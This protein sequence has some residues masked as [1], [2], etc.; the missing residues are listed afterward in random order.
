MRPGLRALLNALEDC[1]IEEWLAAR[2]PGSSAWIDRY[3]DRLFPSRGAG[4]TR[5]PLFRQFCLGAIHE[6]WHGEL[7]PL[8]ERAIAALDTTRDARRAFIDAMP[9]TSVDADL[10]GAATYFAS[11]L[12]TRFRR[13]DSVFPP[14]SFERAVR[15]AAWQSWSIAWQHIRPE[16]ERLL[17][18]D[19]CCKG[20]EVASA[21]QQLLL[22]LRE[23]RWVG[24][25]RG[26]RRVV[27]VSW[28]AG[29]PF[30]GVLSSPARPMGLPELDPS[31]RSALQATVRAAP[32]NLWDEAFRVVAPLAD[33][34]VDE[35][36][37]RLLPDAFPRW[38]PGYATGSRLDLRAATQLEADPRALYRLWQRKT[39]PK[40]VDPAFF[41]L[42]DLSGSMSGDRIE[43]GFRG[44]V[45]LAS[46]LER[47][48]VPFAVEG[49]QDVPIPFK[50]LG[51]PLDAAA[52]RLLGEMPHECEARRRNGHNE[53]GHNHD[54]PV[55]V[56]VAARF[57]RVTATRRLLVVVSDGL[58]SG[59]SSGDPELLL[60]GAIRSIEAAGD[61]ELIGV[62]I[63]PGTDHVA[64]LY[65]RSLANVPLAEFPMALGQ[66]ID[67]GLARRGARR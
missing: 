11:P 48:G 6:W 63:G 7:P 5:Q 36:Q 24:E 58:P 46:V 30:P 9:P 49:F 39:L 15:V 54:G 23:L 31:E 50:A 21:E 67:R 19:P 22:L 37:R 1:R 45:L 52:Q 47:L 57:A 61:I 14:D 51:A 20:A 65:P 27:R 17:E 55:L 3:N 12:A 13:S 16:Y 64:R 25:S 59:P 2:F 44:V 35:L 4:L 43:H 40:K 53:P 29:L 32:Q 28:P 33:R 41:L 8:D 34:M 66:T 56:D 38:V 60:R 62:G 18:G 42:L 10:G 26:A